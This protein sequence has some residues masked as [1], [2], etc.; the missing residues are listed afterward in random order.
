MPEHDLSGDLA[1]R[2]DFLDRAAGDRFLRHAEHDATLLVLRTRGS[3]K[4]AHLEEPSGAVVAHSGHDDAERVA[5]GI[6]R[7]RTEQDVGGGA[8]PRYRRAVLDCNVIA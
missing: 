2:D 7:G 5:A 1:E 3:T 4:L 6:L 8:M